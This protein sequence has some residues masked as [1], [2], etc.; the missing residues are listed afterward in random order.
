MKLNE[1]ELFVL[2]KAINY[3][4]DQLRKPEQTLY[5]ETKMPLNKDIAKMREIVMLDDILNKIYLETN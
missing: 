3:Y 1:Q 4:I 5:Q 2:R